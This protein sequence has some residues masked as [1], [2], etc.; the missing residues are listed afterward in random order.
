MFRNRG[1][2]WCRII[3]GIAL[4]VAACAP[5]T[6]PAPAPAAPVPTV[7][8]APVPEPSKTAETPPVAAA[9]GPIRVGILNSLSG[10]MAVT[11]TSLKDVALMKIEELNAAGGV[12]GRKLEPVVVDPASNWP[13]FAEKARELLVKDQVAVVFGCYTSVSRKSV[14]PVFEELNGLLFY[15]AQYEGEE[16]SP[17]VFYTGTTPDQQ[18]I[19]AVEWLLSPEGGAV[20]RFVFIGTDYVLPRV[21]NKLLRYFVR[22]KGVSDADVMATYTPFGHEDYASTVAQIARF[23]PGKPTAVISMLWGE[24]N[25]SF[26]RELARQGLTPGRLRVV[27]LSVTEDELRG[28]EPRPFVGQLAAWSYFMS[29]ETPENRQ[30]VDAW[31]AYAKA[32]QLPDAASR[33]TF[34]PMEA[35]YLGV[36]LWARAVQAAGSTDIDPVREALAAQVVKSPSGFEL[37]FDP[38]TQHLSKPAFLGEITDKRQFKIRWKSAA[39]IRAQP[40]HPLIPE[41]RGRARP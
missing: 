10:T 35:T 28:V 34:D 40:W 39:P 22:S 24:S 16:S 31:K 4:A 29:L 14:L 33:V 18:A 19:P 12:L 17:N 1:G 27:S 38:R 23:L 20:R 8:A 30:F 6:Q 32:K 21:T 3:G 37:A 41:N 2:A 36:A 7:V 13:L 9:T 26:Y 11:E 25:P 15:P 5:A